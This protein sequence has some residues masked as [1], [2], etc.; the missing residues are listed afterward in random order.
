MKLAVSNIAWDKH[1]DLNVLTELLN[2]GVKGIEVAPTKIWP[3]WVGASRSS[4]IDYR[5]KMQKLGLEIPAMQALL[6]NRPDLQLFNKD[7][8][9]DFFKHIRLLAEIAN[10]FGAGVLVFGSPNNR[11]RGDISLSQADVLAYEFFSM[12]AN[13]CE[14]M[15]CVM[16]L[17]HNPVEYGCDFITNARDAK[18]LVDAVNHESFKLHLD[19]GGLYMCG[20]DIRNEIINLKEFSHFHASEPM[21]API[22]GGEVDFTEV[23]A[24]LCL[25]GYDGWVSI[26]MKSVADMQ[27]LFNSVNKIRQ[28]IT[29]TI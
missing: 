28:S 1:D 7:T 16:A 25:S 29:H 19:S 6:F 24:G 8:H 5:K 14:E 21:L 15:D 17:E 13:I 2:L 27:V 4:A 11:R 18:A 26:E 20:S 9:V 3:N 10:G 12:A 22:C 23:A